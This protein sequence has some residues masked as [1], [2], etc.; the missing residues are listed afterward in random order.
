MGSYA[1]L[2]KSSKRLFCS[3]WN[4]TEWRKISLPGTS[5]TA[6]NFK[7]LF[8]KTYNDY[9]PIKIVD[10]DDVD[11]EDERFVDEL[12]VFNVDSDASDISDADE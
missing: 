6:S 4:W 3:N 9:C 7:C 10:E 8:D 11:S 12:M 2:W 1:V 5:M